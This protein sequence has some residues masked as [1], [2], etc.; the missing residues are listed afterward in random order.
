M[1]FEDW[2]DTPI[3]DLA[4]LYEAEGRRW[5]DD[6]GWDMTP[7]WRIVE[8][9]RR[10]GHVPGL[11]V[12]RPDGG[13]AGWAF[14]L[15]HEGTLQI[16]GIVGATAAAVRRLLERILQSP[17]AGLA[18]GFSGFLFP[19][20]PSLQS[21]LERHR[22]LLARHLYLARPLDASTDPGAGP[23]P[24]GLRAAALAG[25]EP[26]DV[27]R[28]FARAYAGRPEA[29]CFA[30]D[31]RLEQWAHYLGQLLGTPAVGRY[32]PAASFV[33]VDRDTSRALGVVVT[34]SLSPGTAHIAQ[35][36]VD[37]ACRRGGLARWLLQ[38]ACNAAR[39]TGHD[40][41]SLLVAESNE[42][43]RAL[44]GRF[45]FE[46]TAHFLWATRPVLAR[47]LGAPATRQVVV[48]A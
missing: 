19:A 1:I 45:G 38:A 18:R 2:R 29:R 10:A 23:E 28:L 12:R 14:Y 17:E 13:A 32:M 16:G 39:T 3:G 31:A 8:D 20:S 43:A 9:A 36:V 40:R 48:G 41:M 47:R 26:A 6:L 25:I 34:T 35:I 24:A 15:L 33:L 11:V 46:Q 4:G 30:P 21:A 22:F 7:S 42:P 5:L 27:V 44:Y 37:P